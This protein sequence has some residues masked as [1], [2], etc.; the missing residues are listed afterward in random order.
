MSGET[1]SF[2]MILGPIFRILLA[3]ATKLLGV[4]FNTFLLFHPLLVS[5]QDVT[6]ES[7]VAQLN[8]NYFKY[9]W[10]ETDRISQMYW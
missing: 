10:G 9:R 8:V 7:V 6:L 1:V 5:K 4:H 3:T 2:T